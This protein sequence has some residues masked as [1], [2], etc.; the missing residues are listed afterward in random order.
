MNWGRGDKGYPQGFCDAN[1]LRALDCHDFGT[2][3]LV[4]SDWEL[5]ELTGLDPGLSEGVNGVDGG[6]HRDGE[7]ETEEGVKDGVS[8]LSTES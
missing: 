3:C 6:E 1:T 5:D 4:S 7:D 8:D 2:T